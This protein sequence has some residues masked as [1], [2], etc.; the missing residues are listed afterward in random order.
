MG[1]EFGHPLHPISVR[2][3]Q[4]ALQEIA[5]TKIGLYRQLPCDISH[6]IGVANAC[7][8][9]E[10]W[11]GYND[12]FGDLMWELKVSDLVWLI[13]EL[14]DTRFLH[15]KYAAPRER[16]MKDGGSWRWNRPRII[17]RVMLSGD[18]RG[19]IQWSADSEVK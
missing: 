16:L 14:W 12:R 9:Q 8:M 19:Y 1:W 11:D 7:R 4:L 13:A 6:R 2:Q 3:Q 5:S 18:Y 10:H 15:P 17:L